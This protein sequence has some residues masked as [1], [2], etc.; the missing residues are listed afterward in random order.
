[1]KPFSLL[2]FLCACL[3]VFGQRVQVNFHPPGQ[4][5]AGVTNWPAQVQPCGTNTARGAYQTNMAWAD[6]SALRDALEPTVRAAFAADDAAKTTAKDDSRKAFLSLTATNDAAAK[7]AGS[8]LTQLQA[9]GT[10]AQLRGVLTNLVIQTDN[11]TLLL[12]RL[13]RFLEANLPDE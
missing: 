13:R 5:V 7:A 12:A 6:Y 1:M 10:I 4:P 2:L 9:A 8:L 11:N 3:P